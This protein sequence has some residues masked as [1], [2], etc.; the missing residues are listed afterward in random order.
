MRFGS[1]DGRLT[2]V[3][4][5]RG[6][7]VA[8]ASEGR[9]GPD[10]M[11][12]YPVWDE[13]AAWAKDVAVDG[14][15]LD[16]ARLANPLPSPTQVFAIGV[17]YRDHIEEAGGTATRFP[18]VFTKFQTCLAG[19]YDDV[20]LPTGRVDWEVELVVVIGRRAERVP[21][22]AAWDY[23]AGLTVGQDL[24]ERAIQLSGDTP[25]FSMGK[26]FPGFGPLGPVVVTPDELADPDDLELGCSVNDTVMQK[27]RTSEL[28]FPVA[29][30][31]SY[32]SGI[33]P[34]LPGDIIFTG[35]PAGVG[36]FR[37]PRVFLRPGDVVTSWVQGIGE[38]RNAA[39]ATPTYRP[40][41]EGK[42][43]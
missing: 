9:F 15:G 26:S 14:F 30:L 3:E 38:L 7:D 35:T 1:Y 22:D 32:I 27:S 37:S 39:T 5:A 8:T 17:N 31:V 40:L 42:A 12:V 13:F 25:Q 11:A 18:L 41:T 36:A 16:L 23:V 20:P 24:S 6:L 33:T 4:G 21:Q 29:E 19:P 34:M 2:L 43:S 28:I 10:P